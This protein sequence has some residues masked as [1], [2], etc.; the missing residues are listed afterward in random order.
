M[1]ESVEDLKD[2]GPRLSAI[3][4]EL[5]ELYGKVNSMIVSRREESSYDELRALH[6]IRKDLSRSGEFV[7]MVE[8]RIKKLNKGGGDNIQDSIEEFIF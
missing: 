3:S 5:N 8:F 7:D 4:I 2:Y 1:V 6:E